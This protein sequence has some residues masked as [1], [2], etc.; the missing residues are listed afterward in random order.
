MPEKQI[1][2][3]LSQISDAHIATTG[4]A[5]FPEEE[6]SRRRSSIPMQDFVLHPLQS[7]VDEEDEEEEDM[8]EASI[9]EIKV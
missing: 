3:R 4:M 9:H 6:R 1:G 8:W 2:R 5:A 7:T